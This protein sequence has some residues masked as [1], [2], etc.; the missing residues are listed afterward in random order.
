MR[1]ESDFDPL[2]ARR[3]GRGSEISVRDEARRAG[4]PSPLL[5]KAVGAPPGGRGGAAAGRVEAGREEF[6]DPGVE[7]SRAA[8]LLRCS[9]EEERGF[10]IIS[11]ADRRLQQLLSRQIKVRVQRLLT[12]Y[13]CKFIRTGFLGA[14]A[15]VR[16]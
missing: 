4:D 15:R 10:A 16:E 3:S 5:C 1:K 8:R 2:N 11:N 13:L 7:G 6:D 9:Q 14:F 12:R